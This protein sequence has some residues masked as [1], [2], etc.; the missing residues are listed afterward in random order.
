MND[1][2][3]YL[4]KLR[5]DAE[6]CLMISEAGANDAKREIFRML[7]AT[8]QNLAADLEKIIALNSIADDERERRLIGVLS[9][10]D[11]VE[12]LAEL[13]KLLGQHSVTDDGQVSIGS[14]VRRRAPLG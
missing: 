5:S 14:T 2:K 7:A 1:I 4:K 9:G 13:A 3:L 8:Y 6:D 12:Q 11:G 10:D